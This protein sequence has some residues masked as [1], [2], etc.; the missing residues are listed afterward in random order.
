MKKHFSKTLLGIGAHHDDCEYA[1]FGSD[2][3]SCNNL[4]IAVQET[5]TYDIL[6]IVPE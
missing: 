1:A 2:S 4:V 6:R 3:I 5:R